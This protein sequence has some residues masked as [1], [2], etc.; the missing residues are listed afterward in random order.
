MRLLRL[1]LTLFP[2]FAGGRDK[3]VSPKDTQELI[4]LAKARGSLTEV[5]PDYAH[6]FMDS[7][8][9]VH[10]RRLELIKSFLVGTASQGAR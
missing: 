8:I 3:V 1:V 6:P 4:D 5:Q 9:A 10:Q 7:D 2:L